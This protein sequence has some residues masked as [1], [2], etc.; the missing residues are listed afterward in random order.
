MIDEHRSLFPR[1]W[2]DGAADCLRH[3]RPNC[4]RSAKGSFRPAARASP[5][6]EVLHSDGSSNE[7][8]PG[9]IEMQKRLLEEEGHGVIPKGKKYVVIDFEDGLVEM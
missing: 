2:S 6:P 4:Y 1:A 3:L 7:E 5:P 8:Y 9:N